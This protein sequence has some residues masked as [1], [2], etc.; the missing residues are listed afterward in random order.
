MPPPSPLGLDPCRTALLWNMARVV[1][2]GRVAGLCAYR[3]RLRGGGV[4]WR[5]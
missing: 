5:T 2:H 3:G 4:R 1:A